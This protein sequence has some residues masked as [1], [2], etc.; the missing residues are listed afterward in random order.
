MYI[1]EEKDPILQCFIRI[2]NGAFLASYSSSLY[3]SKRNCFISEVKKCYNVD[4]PYMQ[5]NTHHRFHKI[6]FKKTCILATCT[7]SKVI[8]NIIDKILAQ[9]RLYTFR[10][11]R[12]GSYTLLP[13]LLS[14]K[15]LHQPP[16][17]STIQYDVFISS[18][19]EDCI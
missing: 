6:E 16:C 7:L 1:F 5:G 17:Y 14:T 2:F 10:D 13:V 9:K 15:T 4:N 19:Y 8:D 12:H 18:I 11:I 3:G